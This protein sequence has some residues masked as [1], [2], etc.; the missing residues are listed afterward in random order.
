[1][2]KKIYILCVA[3]YPNYG[4]ELILNTWLNWFA[5]NLNVKTNIVIDSIHDKELFFMLDDIDETQVSLVNDI[6]IL[7]NKH[8]TSDYRSNIL[9][10][11][12]RLVVT[13][14]KPFRSLVKETEI[15]FDTYRRNIYRE[16]DANFSHSDSH[17]RDCSVVHTI[18][19]GYL[20]EMM[21][22]NCGLLL[23]SDFIMRNNIN[24]VS[25]LT[26]TGLM[27]KITYDFTAVQKLL[28]QITYSETR[29][30]VSAETYSLKLGLD[31]AFLGVDHEIHRFAKENKSEIPDVMVC[32]QTDLGDP[33]SVEKTI[34]SVRSKLLSLKERGLSIGYA[35]ALPYSD[36]YAYTKLQDLIQEKYW[37]SAK[38]C[39][40]FGLPVKRN[41]IWFTTR[42]HHHLVA[43]SAGALG[44]AISYK[45]GYYDIKHK[46]LL[47]LDTGWGYYSPYSDVSK[48]PEPEK[49]DKFELIVKDY[50]AQKQALAKEIYKDFI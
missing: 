2:Q 5:A 50:T 47:D 22:Y 33:L 9:S 49:N 43:A 45:P 16:L 30:K 44:V 10:R 20:N 12:F 8:Y 31:D 32:I 14:I 48:F 27:P 15:P 24:C 18:G 38:K 1:M 6:S 46:S 40:R 39:I 17:L 29:D 34:E 42:F 25:A 3:G 41:Q 21:K 4:D 19:G 7:A 37:F 36:H 35:E 13:R 26:G 28:S 11:L 23:G